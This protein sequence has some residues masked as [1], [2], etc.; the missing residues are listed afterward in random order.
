MRVDLVKGGVPVVADLVN[1]REAVEGEE[2]GGSAGQG[3]LG[4]ESE[5]SRPGVLGLLGAEGEVGEG[6]AL[7]EVG[8]LGPVLLELQLLEGCAVGPVDALDHLEAVDWLGE[9]HGL[10][11][12]D[13]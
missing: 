12:G 6:G 2:H 1:V 11:V 9:L 13:G 10:C 4:P 3:K 7:L 5:E 8:E